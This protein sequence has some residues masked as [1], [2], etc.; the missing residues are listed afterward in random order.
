MA[1]ILN[2]DNILSDIYSNKELN[3]SQATE[4]YYSKIDETQ[5]FNTL[6]SHYLNSNHLV[7]DEALKKAAKV[8]ID[9]KYNFINP[10]NSFKNNLV[11]S[12]ILNKKLLTLTFSSVLAV[13][14]SGFYYNQSQEQHYI[15]SV[16]T[17][18]S[19]MSNEISNTLSEEHKVSSLNS[20]FIN[21]LDN[22]L[23]TSHNYSPTFSSNQEKLDLIDKQLLSISSKYKNKNNN[24]SKESADTLE[25]TIEQD[26]ITLNNIKSNLSS[27][28]TT[29]NNYKGSLQ[30][31]NNL[32]QLKNSV[33]NSFYDTNA[34]S[35]INTNLIQAQNA[36]EQND[37]KLLNN[38][39]EFVNKVIKYIEADITFKINQK[40][41][42]IERKN[43]DNPNIKNHY[44]IV[45]SIDSSG[46]P[47]EAF[48]NNYETKNDIW[49]TK[50]GVYI[51]NETYQK[52]KQ[53][54]I[55][56]GVISNDIVGNKPSG[57]FSIS[58]SLIPNT[59]N[60][61]TEW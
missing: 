44:L 9:T 17:N 1:K 29:F 28:K 60:Y 22:T 6:K 42:G 12:S 50:F 21:K 49:T 56:N 52:I 24:L 37:F 3:F 40:P 5:L 41:S 33:S 38:K 10:I 54:K 8:F 18:Y 4:E 47:I 53:D 16:V 43:N 32:L 45:N 35:L 26:N 30:Q 55:K 58:Y 23:I 39:V 13:L 25:N 11:I 36:L 31:E 34:T 20:D 61:I 48:V 27:I 19:N 51:D 7:S 46:L 59:S 14:S 2:A 57:Q 15:D